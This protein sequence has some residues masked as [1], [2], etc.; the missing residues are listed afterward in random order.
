MT[1][2]N[3][4]QAALEQIVALLGTGNCKRGKRLAAFWRAGEEL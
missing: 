2:T 1:T 3:E 4:M